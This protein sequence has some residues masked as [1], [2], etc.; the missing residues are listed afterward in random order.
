MDR[1]S[2]H[3]AKLTERYI[4]VGEL[5][6]THGLAGWLKLKSFDPNSAA[7]LS[8]REIV[9]ARGAENT[10][11]T[12][13]QAKRHK[14]LFL[15]KLQGVDQIAAA[16]E[17]VGS[18]VYLPENALT[19]LREHEYYYRD[20]LGFDV[21]DTK[22]NHLGKI[23]RI[24]FKA[25]GDLYVVAGPDK[26]HLIPAT[27]EMIEAVDLEQRRITVDLPDGLLEL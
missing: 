7:L 18:E 13:E 3:A 4:S 2:N 12:V 6:G 24:W 9:L 16:E 1:S 5:V 23:A 8:A 11:Y 17:L 14:R 19:P 21:F 15:I 25:G 20:V 10:S 22:S 27:R 26:E